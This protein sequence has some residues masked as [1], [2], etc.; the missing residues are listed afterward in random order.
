MIFLLTSCQD[1]LQN[2]PDPRGYFLAQKSAESLQQKK[3][4][5]ALDTNLQSLVYFDRS[6]Q[7]FSNLGVAFDLN[8]KKDDAEKSFLAALEKATLPKDKFL[9]Y[10][11]LGYLMGSQKKIKEA[12]IYYQQ[13]LEI[14]PTSKEVKHNIELLTQKQQ[15][16]DQSGNQGESSEKKDSSGQ[17]DQ[18]KDEQKKDQDSSKNE[19]QKDEKQKD[20]QGE[21]DRKQTGAYKPRPFKGDQ[22]SEGDVKKI[23][24][25]L[26][27]QDQKIRSQFNK[28][29]NR[30]EE[31]NGKDW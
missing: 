2:I 28:K 9:I 30:K 3:N 18:Q 6:Y 19:D 12:L 8:E 29:E 31:S 11:N 14:D 25:E 1:L 24:G 15:S 22:L 5:E 17:G 10:F 23:L 27:R 7:I 13:A 26:S 16:Q 20:Q 4:T 21:K